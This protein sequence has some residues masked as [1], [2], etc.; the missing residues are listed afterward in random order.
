MPTTTTSIERARA[1]RDRQREL[2]DVLQ[3][4]GRL[5]RLD[6]FF[7]SDVVDHSAPPGLPPGVEGV[8]AV[9]GAIRAA[10]PDHDAQI[11]HIVAEGDLVATY[12][13]LTGTHM[14]D[15]FGLAATGLR[16]TIRVMDFVRYDDGR[17]A[18]HWNIVDLAGLRAQL[19]V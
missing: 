1:N 13:T 2:V 15:F 18:E 11:V 17:V 8:R 4:R 10:F 19:G 12:K 6:E 3:H 7:A 14:G 16:A 9:L 5:E